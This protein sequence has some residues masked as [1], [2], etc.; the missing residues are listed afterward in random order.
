MNLKRGGGDE[1]R[2]KHGLTVRTGTDSCVTP[3]RRVFEVV[4]T[5]RVREA[6]NCN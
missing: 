2:G 6:S 1:G 4:E 5:P 3:G